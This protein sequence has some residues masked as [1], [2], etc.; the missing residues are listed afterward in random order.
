M[1]MTDDRLR[2]REFLTVFDTAEIHLIDKEK[3]EVS[4]DKKEMYDHVVSGTDW[5]KD[6]EL[7]VYCERPYACESCLHRAM[8]ECTGDGM[9]NEPCLDFEYF[10]PNM[11]VFG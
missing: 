8:W 9:S 4:W 3:G 10:S 5:T 7:I 6:R 11:A 2:L 1:K